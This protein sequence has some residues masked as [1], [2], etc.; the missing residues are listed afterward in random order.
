MSLQT[1]PHHVCGFAYVVCIMKAWFAVLCFEVERYFLCSL[2]IV[3]FG[4]Y[5]YVSLH[6]VLIFAI[7][8]GFLESVCFMVL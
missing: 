2:M 6:K 4:C 5:S 3:L 8:T 7:C 1:T